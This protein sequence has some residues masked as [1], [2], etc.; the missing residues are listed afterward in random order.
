MLE[1]AEAKYEI[2]ANLTHAQSEWV[3]LNAIRK[4]IADKKIGE[5]AAADTPK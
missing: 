1:Q 5:G 4:E 2:A 3:R